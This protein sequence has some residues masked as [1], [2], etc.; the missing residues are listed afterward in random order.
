MN[1]LFIEEEDYVSLRDSIDQHGNI[2]QL[3]IAKRL[4]KHELLEFRRIAAHLYKKNRRWRQ[5]IALS[6]QDRLFRDAMET[7]AES[8]DKE[9]TE[10]LLRY[11][12]EV[13]KRECFAAMLYTC[14][15]LL[16]PDVVFELAWRHNLKNFAMPYMI[17]LLHEQYHRVCIDALP[18]IESVFIYMVFFRSNLWV[19]MW[20]I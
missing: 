14:Y 19:V 4:E 3:D 9:V 11:F 10:E 7:A 13:G 2:D 17:N 18:T 15:D 5:S 20:M 16:R 6:K 12:I 8:R 1:E